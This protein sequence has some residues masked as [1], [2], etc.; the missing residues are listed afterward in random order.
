M[1]RLLLPQAMNSSDTLL[2]H[3]G[4]PYLLVVGNEETVATRAVDRLPLRWRAVDHGHWCIRKSL[5]LP[6]PLR[7][8]W[9]RHYQEA[10]LHLASAPQH[11][12]GR[13]GLLSFVY[14]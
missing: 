3:L 1:D 7:L 13:D 8:E 2:Q 4:V 5:P 9:G 14:G 12:A 10:P 6:D 11:V